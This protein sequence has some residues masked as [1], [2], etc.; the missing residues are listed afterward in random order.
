MGASQTLKQ[1]KRIIE[2]KGG[3]VTYMGSVEWWQKK[4]DRLTKQLIDDM[5]P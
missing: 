1:L 5:K 3:S 4:I 2:S